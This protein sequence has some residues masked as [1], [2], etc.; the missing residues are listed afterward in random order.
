MSTHRKQPTT[1]ELAQQSSQTGLDA[2]I[3]PPED[4]TDEKDDVA[5]HII[6]VVTEE[7]ALQ[8]Y[9]VPVAQTETDENPGIVESLLSDK[10][11]VTQTPAVIPTR[12]TPVTAPT[13]AFATSPLQTAREA[14]IASIVSVLLACALVCLTVSMAFYAVFESITITLT[15][16]EQRFS[17]TLMLHLVTG[18]PTS[19]SQVEARRLPPISLSQVLTTAATGSYHQQPTYALGYV[20]FYN[21]SLTSVTIQAGMQFTGQD[22]VMIV[23]AKT[24]SVPGVDLSANPPSLGQATVAAQ[25]ANMGSRGNI[26]A[27]DIN[28]TCSQCGASI[29]V[30]NTQAFTGG[31]D[32][33]TFTIVQQ[34][35]ID[36]M[37]GPLTAALQH[38]MTSAIQ[39]Q[40]RPGESLLVGPCSLAFHTNH[41]AG[42]EAQS[43]TLIASETCSGLA[44]TQDSVQENSL[45]LAQMQAPGTHFVFLPV[46]DVRIVSTTL[47]PIPT[48]TTRVK[49]VFA[50]LFTSS[51]RHRVA[52]A[53]AGLKPGEAYQVL[54]KTAGIDKAAISGVSYNSAL[55]YDPTRITIRFLY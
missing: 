20:T 14:K 9:F 50:Y 3:A 8:G 11:D 55:P 42:E 43:V 44:Y 37:K 13:Q 40:V 31:Q 51:E 53:I 5:I 46:P 39:G 26:Q 22:G 36:G 45:K 48:I 10:Q 54:R 2:F 17:D 21:G 25:A 30:K 27:Y 29:I 49:G 12:Q 52:A 15:P 23:T 47:T 18:V 38:S 6:P 34:S 24:V 16:L 28:G 33:K 32:A 1:N 7:G 35:D 19:L 41:R 4:T